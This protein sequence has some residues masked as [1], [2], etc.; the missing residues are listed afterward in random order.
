MQQQLFKQLTFL[1]STVRS[2][3]FHCPLPIL[4]GA[5]IGQHIRHVLEFYQ[6]LLQSLT[7]G[8]VCYDHRPRDPRLETDRAFALSQLH[9]LQAS[10]TDLEG[11]RH[12][13]LLTGPPEHPLRVMT[14]L[15]RELLYC[16]EHAIHHLALVKIGVIQALPYL[17]LPEG[18]G[19]APAT[20]HYRAH[21]PL[22]S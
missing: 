22:A 3:D 7:D 11:E 16:L 21:K 12:L 13:S 18:F 19:I 4:S 10:L 5:T 20:L 2:E 6:C 1:L 15:D 9:Q 17:T 14:S 8:Q